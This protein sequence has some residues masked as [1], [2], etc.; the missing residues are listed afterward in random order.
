MRQAILLVPTSR[1]ATSTERFCASGFIFGVT[2]D[3][4]ASSEA[5][6]RGADEQPVGGD[7]LRGVEPPRPVH[8]ETLRAL[9]LVQRE[10]HFD[11]AKPKGKEWSEEAFEATFPRLVRLYAR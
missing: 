2:P 9:E 4:S 11:L 5:G 3:W 8:Q 1:A 7:D 6:V 10:D